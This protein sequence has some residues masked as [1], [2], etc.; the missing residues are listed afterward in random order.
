MSTEEL[1]V[2][3]QV[4]AAGQTDKVLGA[5]GAAG[6]FMLT[7]TCVVATAATSQVQIKDG[8][9][10]A[11]TI[12]PN[13]VAQGIGTYSFY[14]ALRSQAGAWK[15]TTAAGVSVIVSGTFT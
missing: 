9:G 15:I 8:G 4:V 3:Y 2:H 1:S 6:D 12:L 11:I 13:A 10:A 7:I 5:V 14:V